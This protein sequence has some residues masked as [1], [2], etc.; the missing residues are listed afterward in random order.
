[1]GAFQA[2]SQK[3][4][5]QKDTSVGLIYSCGRFS[6]PAAKGLSLKETSVG[7]YTAVGAYWTLADI[8]VQT[9]RHSPLTNNR[10]STS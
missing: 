3:D 6:G 8:V 1:M 9:I 4:F 10:C 5:R 7:C 2:L